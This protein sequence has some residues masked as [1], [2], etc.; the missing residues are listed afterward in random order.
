MG[1]VLFIFL[2]SIGI[3]SVFAGDSFFLEKKKGCI[4]KL[5]SKGSFNEV[6]S[7]GFISRTLDVKVLKKNPGMVALKLT[8]I[9][10]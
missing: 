9:S 7:A 10:M 3:S 4:I 5:Y 8:T 1:K 6:D 2:F